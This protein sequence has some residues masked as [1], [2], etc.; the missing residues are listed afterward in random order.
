MTSVNETAAVNITRG[1]ISDLRSSVSGT[2]SATSAIYGF[3]IPAVAGGASTIS[4]TAC[5]TLFFASDGSACGAVG[6]PWTSGAGI[7]R[8]RAAVGFNPL[9]SGTSPTGVRLLITW[10][11]LADRPP[12]IWPSN[13]SGSYEIDTA[14]NRN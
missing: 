9:S 4:G 11:A 1:I 8:Y 13:Y 3:S 10:P 14:L 6:A 7:P 12:N 2:A 5:Q